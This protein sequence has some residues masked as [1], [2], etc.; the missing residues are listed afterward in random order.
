MPSLP[1]EL[2]SVSDAVEFTIGLIALMQAAVWYTERE[3][4]MPW[5][6]AGSL[7]TT[8]MVTRGLMALPASAPPERPWLLTMYAVRDLF[9]LGLLAYMGLRGRAWLAA[10]IVLTLPGALFA[11]ALLAGAAPPGPLPLPLLWVDLGMSLICLAAARRQP[12]AGHDLLAIAPLIGPAL[13]LLEPWRGPG[14]RL[15]HDF[16]LTVIGF[17]IVILVAGLRRQSR[18]SR[19]A[20]ARAQ[21]MTD[22]YAALSHTNQAILRIR[23]VQALCDEICRICVRWGHVQM[24]CVYQKDGTLARRVAADGPALGVLQGLPDPW[25]LEGALAQGSYTALA[26]REGVRTISHDYQADPRS[27]PWRALASAHGVRTVAWLPLR[28]DTEVVAV[29]M[30]AAAE[31]GSFTQALVA[32]LD[33]M[34]QDISFAFDNI[35]RDA[36]HAAAAREVQAGLD[37]FS[38]LF[39]TAPVSAAII[40]LAD[41]TIIDAN[42]AM[43]ERHG[44][45]RQD[46]IGRTT[47]SL[48]YVADPADREAFYRQLGDEGRVRNVAMRMVRHDGA[49]RIDLMNAELIDYL[50]RPCFLL[51]TLDITELRAAQDARQALA[52]AQAASRAKTQFLSSMSHELRTPL[53]AVLGFSGLLRHEA[54]D[55]LTPQQL[56][57]LDH[58]QQAGWHLL[59]LIND[60]LDLSRIEAGQFDVSNRSL[61]LA[62]L[63]DE[64]L[65]MSQPPAAKAGI[66]LH[67]PYRD[68]PPLWALA[69]PTRLRQVVLNVLSNAIKYGRPRG[70]VHVR[71][72]RRDDGV[73]IEIVDTGLGM[74][75]QQL[76]HLFEPF[77]RL[78]RDGQGIEGT[79]IGLS[80]TRQLM[81]LMSGDVEVASQQDVGTCVVLRLPWADGA[82]HEP[83]PAPP[84]H[85][86]APAATE[87]PCGSVLYI[88]DN[89]VNSLLVE[90]LLARW[91]GVRFVGASDGATGIRM[92]LALRP[93]LVLL[94]LQ[95]PDIDGLEVLGRLRA[96][97]ALRETPIIV[98]SAT[99]MPA[100]IAQARARGATDYWTKP[101]DFQRFLAGIAA[102]LPHGERGTDGAPASP[103]A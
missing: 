11:A 70:T 17:G 24:A 77:N 64:A 83:A 44:M 13:V 56:A 57:Q 103:P 52:E 74:S 88:E 34:T 100:D 3:R 61:E 16:P 38:R 47:S 12:G 37:R 91:D 98:L 30:L 29:L 20:Q 22:F 78:G 76:E 82:L 86:P 46:M 96:H 45:A 36:R 48:P 89:E 26:L 39:E 32:L 73:T 65:Q 19:R 79:G 68:E 80:L 101:L 25:D 55:R 99:A 94:D 95:L 9:A 93:D 42:Q 81:Q 5:F 40:S 2:H 35:D 69:D 85:D 4:G 43:C 27:G 7:L 102:L 6:V 90:Q 92:A 8:L 72:L 21:R 66:T 10:A 1:V 15:N 28:R 67:A 97:K 63:L 49:P 87:P 50:G 53:N 54:A 51:M 62:P 59:R 41:R 58:V 60:V 33:E 84:A 14:P 71:T 23:D 18:A 31:A 75:P